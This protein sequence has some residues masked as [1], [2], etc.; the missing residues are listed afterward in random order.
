MLLGIG[1][2]L[3]LE[4]ANPYVKRE[5]ELQLGLR[6]PI[7]AR[8]PRLSTRVAHGYLMGQRQL[9]SSAWKGYRTLRASLATAGPDG[10]FPRSILITS[11]SPNDGKSMTAV[12]LAITLA[13]ADM[14]VILVDADLHRPMI[15][16][17]FNF[18]APPGGFAA[19]LSE[20]MPA[21]MALVDAPAHPQLRLLSRAGRSSPRGGSSTLR[22]SS[23]RPRS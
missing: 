22:A 5:D 14:N 4:M 3:I 9:P 19:V 13:A 7:L 23:V 12:N 17:I 15:A 11:A 21:G 10:K 2:A 1:L 18:G 20:Q 8:I 6:L 16:T